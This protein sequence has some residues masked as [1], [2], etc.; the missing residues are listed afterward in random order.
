MYNMSTVKNAFNQG[1]PNFFLQLAETELHLSAKLFRE[2]QKD[3]R[4]KFKK[5]KNSV[6]IVL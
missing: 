5:D 1:S 6:I 2:V 4:M 3:L